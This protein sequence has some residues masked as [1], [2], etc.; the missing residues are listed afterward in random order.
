MPR[1][2]LSVF[3]QKPGEQGTGALICT[4]ASLGD[5]LRSQPSSCRW[6]W[7]SPR[8]RPAPGETSRPQAVKSKS[9]SA[10]TKLDKGLLTLVEKGATKRV[11]VYMTV[12]T[13][14][15][16]GAAA[17]MR[18]GRNANAGDIRW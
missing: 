17:I 3:V 5:V 13:D 4:A 6:S 7:S 10:R 16:A 11:F 2:N 9:D 12:K 8:R 15:A 1:R 18:R 14:A